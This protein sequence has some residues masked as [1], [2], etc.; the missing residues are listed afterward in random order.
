MVLKNGDELN[1][2]I[3]NSKKYAWDYF[4]LHSSQRMSTFNF[5]ILISTII[6]SAYFVAIREIPVLSLILALILIIFS[7]V[8]W[9]WD[10]RTRQMIKNAEAALKYL[11]KK[12][13][14]GKPRNDSEILN[15]FE[16]EEFQTQKRR[17]IKAILPWKVF[18]SY[19]TCLNTI[20]LTFGIFGLIGVVWSVI[21]L[22]N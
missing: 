10:I 4:A 22:L 7:F 5:F 20:F 17:E 8:F 2:K 3:N 9:K 18:F 19:S 12:E 11:E 14:E 6:L 15:I 16:Y 1:N 13:F 21:S